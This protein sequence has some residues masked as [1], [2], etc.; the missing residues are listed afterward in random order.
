MVRDIALED[1]GNI[2]VSGMVVN[3]K[4]QSA[5]AKVNRRSEKEVPELS[6]WQEE[7]D[8]IIISHIAGLLTM[9]L[10]GLS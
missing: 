8:S 6:N 5:K 2:V 9:V 1:F 4:V 7:A 10:R 3:E